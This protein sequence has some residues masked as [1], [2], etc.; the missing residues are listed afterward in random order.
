[1]SP[2]RRSADRRRGGAERLK[3]RG[4]ALKRALPAVLLA[5]ALAGNAGAF[6]VTI[7]GSLN[8]NLYLQIGVGAGGTFQGGGLGNN[9]THS[10]E[11]VAVAAGVVGNGTSQAMTTNSSVTTSAYNGRVFCTVPAQLY[12]G[13]YYQPVL[14]GLFT[15]G[16]S[17]LTATVPANLIDASGDTIPFSS[18][19]WTSTGIGD[20]GSEPFPGG[21]FAAS[22]TQSIGTVAQNQWAESCWT[23]SY[24]NATVPPAGTY[25][26]TVLYTLTSP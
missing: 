11:T 1:M 12:I 19:S 16:S 15:S 8:S 6:T 2:R 13:A 3:S 7:G 9:A 18:I 14:F 24:A 4:L 22:S 26:G 21:T 5:T 23:F 20:S 10:N 17:T 25:T